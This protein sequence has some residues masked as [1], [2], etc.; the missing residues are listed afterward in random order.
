M[1][2]YRNIIRSDP[3]RRD[4][5]PSASDF[6]PLDQAL[7]NSIGERRDRRQRKMRDAREISEAM[8]ERVPRA[9]FTFGE[10]VQFN[11][12]DQKLYEYYT[13]VHQGT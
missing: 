8:Q 5:A 13:R 12:L 10:K 11:G 3:R 4:N 1:Y 6:V 2:G 7:G 9:K